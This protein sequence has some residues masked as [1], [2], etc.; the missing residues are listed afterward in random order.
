[1]TIRRRVNEKLSPTEVTPRMYR[2]LAYIVFALG[3]AVVAVAAL[4]LAAAFRADDRQDSLQVALTQQEATIAALRTANDTL[5]A[6]IRERDEAAKVASCAGA[7]A[8]NG[9]LGTIREMLTLQAANARALI[10][11]SLSPEERAQREEN[12]SRYDRLRDRVRD[13][14]TEACG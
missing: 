14:P 5:T 2:N 12:A 8:A 4:G 7:E 11:E 13:F 10:D 9:V 1:M 3:V 6:S